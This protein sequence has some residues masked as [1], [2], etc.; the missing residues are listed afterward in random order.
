MHSL[1]GVARRNAGSTLQLRQRPRP[2]PLLEILR[3]T[4]ARPVVQ[5]REGPDEGLLG[6]RHLEQLGV[7][8]LLGLATLGDN[9]PQL[10]D[11]ARRKTWARCD[12]ASHQLLHERHLFARREPRPRCGLEAGLLGSAQHSRWR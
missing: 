2:P 11:C 5:Q 6:A 3:A 1:R 12:R 7:D 9:A 10:R 8:K 4:D